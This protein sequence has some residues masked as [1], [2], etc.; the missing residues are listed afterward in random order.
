MVVIAI[1]GLHGAGKTTAAKHLAKKFGL[2][3]V[4]AG[5]VFRQMAKEM[6]MT[7]D[8]FSKYCERRPSIDLKI[9][10]RTIRAAKGK[11]VLIDARLAGWMAKKA[12]VKIL[13]TAP[14][15]VRVKRIMGRESRKYREVLSETRKRELSEA[16]RFKKFYGIDVND[17]SPFDLVLNTSRLD[18][19][20]MIKILEATIASV[21]KKG[22]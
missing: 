9:D 19:E 4:C 8:E 2:K 3:H 12:D 10:K 7:L 22:F 21:I 5:D 13:L 18:V 15:E 6:N 11:N 14:L 17:Y 1:S 20:T 16:K